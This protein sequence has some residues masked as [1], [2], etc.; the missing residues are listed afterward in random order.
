MTRLRATDV[1]RYVRRRWGL[2]RGAPLTFSQMG[3]GVLI[4]GGWVGLGLAA[5]VLAQKGGL[6]IVHGGQWLE[7]GNSG[8]QWWNGWL[9]VR[10]AP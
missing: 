4:E 8:Q 3:D 9:E 2:Y 6:V 7:E 5:H 1:S 10:R